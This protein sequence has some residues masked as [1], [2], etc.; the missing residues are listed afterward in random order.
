MIVPVL[1]D[2]RPPFLSPLGGAAG[3]LLLTPLGGAP[4]LVELACAIRAVCKSDQILIAPQFAADGAYVDACEAVWPCAKIASSPAFR[5]VLDEREPSD[6][7]LIVDAAF[8]PTDGLPLGEM[9]QD[10]AACP[11]SRHLISV[12]RSEHGVDEGVVRD[13]AGQVRRIERYYEG[14]TS[15]RASAVVASAVRAVALRRVSPDA[16]PRPEAL[17]AQLAAGAY[18]ARDVMLGGRVLDLCDEGDFLRVSGLA[19]ESMLAERLPPG[20]A[21]HAPGVAVAANVSIAPSARLFGPLVIHSGARIES[22]AV[23]IGPTTV[24]PNAVVGA[25]ALVCEC[26]VP[27]GQAIADGEERCQQVASPRGV[28]RD[29]ERGPARVG[30]IGMDL[31]PPSAGPWYPRAKRAFDFSVALAALLALSPLLL[32]LALLVRFT[33]RGG[34]YFGHLREGRGALPFR[35]WKFRTM[36]ADADA[37]QR[38]LYR[39]NAV[40]GPQFKMKR[41]PRITFVGRIL[42]ATNLDELPQLWNVLRGEMSLIGPRP[43]PFRENQMC[44]PWREARLSVRPGITGLWQVCRRD[45]A[46]SD[47]YQWIHYDTLYVRH[48]SFW[49]DLRILFFTVATL[50]GKFSV[51]VTWIISKNE[52]EQARGAGPLPGIVTPLLLGADDGA[53]APPTEAQNLPRDRRSGAVRGPAV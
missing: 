30:A 11:L 31:S 8:Y 7:L 43:S 6:W 1:I 15:I 10:T 16:A 26:L 2:C 20:F 9:L 53:A 36:V 25:A 14:I 13:A 45:R 37:K 40:D 21:L 46:I 38:G 32:I 52:L 33:S 28:V 17:R 23:V 49:V 29:R 44:I 4:L 24:G 39:A 47:F 35:C 51:P 12:H 27:R 3:S 50:A 5:A 41:D 18:P 34:A 22:D 48:A 19:I 42:R